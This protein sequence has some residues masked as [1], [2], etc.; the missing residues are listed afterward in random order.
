MNTLRKPVSAVIVA[1]LA[2]TLALTL[3]ITLSSGVAVAEESAPTGTVVSSITVGQMSDIHYFPLEY[4][5]Q[6]VTAADYKDSDFYYSMTGDTKLVLESGNVLYSNMVRVLEDAKKGEAPTHIFASGDLTKNGERVAEIDVANSLRWLQNSVRALGEVKKADDTVVDYTNF[7]IFATV[8]NHDLYN[9]TGALYDKTSGIGWDAEGITAAQFAMI[10]NGLGYPEIDKAILDEI[11]G[12]DYWASDFTGGYIASTNATNLEIT[13]YNEHFTAIQNKNGTAT[14]KEISEEYTQVGDGR[15]QLSFVAHIKDTAFTLFVLDSTDREPTDEIVPV[16]INRTEFDY[17]YT[18][19]NFSEADFRLLKNVDGIDEYVQVTS[20]AEIISAYEND[21]TVYRNTELTHLC[22]GRID[23]ALYPFLEEI[24]DK[25]STSPDGIEEPTYIAS[26]HQNI[27]PHFDQEDEILKDFTM[28]NWEYTC[29]R[30]LELGIK[31]TFS[32]HQHASD[33]ATYVDAEGRT[34]Y[35]FETGSFVSLD[36]PIRYATVTRYNVDGKLAESVD[37]SLRLLDSIGQTP[38]KETPSTDVYNPANEWNEGAYQSALAVYNAAQDDDAKKAAWAEVVAA[39]P[40]YFTYTLHH[41][42]FASLSYNEYIYQEIYGQLIDRVLSHYLNA[43]LRTTVDDL[44]ETY[45]GEDSTLFSGSLSILSGY[46][47]LLYK[48]ANYIVDTVWYNLYPDNDGNGYGDYVVGDKTYDNV[49]DM[50]IAVAYSIIDMEYGTEEAGGKLTL[51]QMAA[52]VLATSCSGNEIS[53][54]LATIAEGVIDTDSLYYTANSPYDE[55]Y[56]KRYQA[57]MQDF[58]AQCDSGK[59]VSDL[60]WGLLNPLYSD[61]DSI[62]KALLDYKFDFINGPTKDEY[63]LDEENEGEVSMLDDLLFLVKGMIPKQ[64]G[65]KVVLNPSNFVLHDIVNGLLPLISSLLG[66]S[67][68]FSFTGTDLYEIVDG[69]LDGYVTDSLFVG[70]GGIAK[71]IVVSFGSDDTPDLAD[72]K[73]PAK[74]LALTPAESLASFTANGKVVTPSYISG[75]RSTDIATQEIGRLPSSLTAN[76]DNVNGTTTFNFSYYTAEEVFTIVRYR[77]V[78]DAEW[79]DATGAHWNIYDETSRNAYYNAS[80]NLEGNVTENGITINTVTSPQYVPL[81]DVGLLCL[82]HGEV[83]YDAVVEGADGEEVEVK[84]YY[85]CKERDA[86]MTG[87][88]LYWNRHNVTISGLEEGAS[89]EYQIYGVYYSTDGEEANRWN[90]ASGLGYDKDFTFTTAKSSGDFKA[91]VISDPQ[92]MIQAMY[93]VTADRMNTLVNDERIQGYDFII[94]G[95]DNTDNPKNFDQWKFWLNSETGIFANTS[96]FSVAGNHEN[97]TYAISKFFNY[98]QPASVTTNVYNGEAEQDY[99]SMDYSGV[100]F[101]FLDT[102]D[103][104]GENGLSEAQYNWLVND[105]STAKTA[106][107]TIVVIMHKSLYSTGSHTNDSEIV[108]M[109]EQLTPVF[110]TYGVKYVFAGH[111]HVYTETKPQGNSGTIYVTLGTIGTKFY[112]YVGDNETVM[113]ALDMDKTIDH[114]LDRQTFGYLTFANGE[115]KYESYTFNDN[116]EVITIEQYLIDTAKNEPV[117]GNLDANDK[118]GLSAGAIAGI[119]IGCVA[120][121]AIIAVGVFFIVKKSKKANGDDEI[122]DY[123]LTEV[124]SDDNNSDAE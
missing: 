13:Y 25:Y 1:V 93:D 110:D 29:K 105:L 11:Y 53:S 16:Q 35:E 54:D 69:L 112:N 28:Y 41:D 85:N 77:K 36:S 122:I 22:G 50:I 90:L 58:A 19:E 123:N 61:D 109:R 117:G 59:L 49:I 104:D 101:A 60:I 119:V 44:V 95:G 21:V 106:G 8:G 80:D 76:F 96:V 67:L 2:L 62:L 71:E 114:T 118:D 97:E 7:Q 81:I 89:Y 65:V 63:K 40:N 37:S 73:D 99:Y 20:Y 26:F 45:L 10:F 103:A 56:R 33:V 48:M 83:Y 72:V 4:C 78:G 82:T 84:M 113:A 108:K 98:T 43:N 86:A 46:R 91:L 12:E 111:D 92:G 55:A 66:D 24:I 115:L 38:L 31:Y 18:A 74:T 124:P 47:V 94:N 70:L 100:H 68:G 42:D 3:G 64:D 5:Y 116:G 32:G 39:N 23:G 15:N 121:V 52:Y 27:M 102:N 30:F 34:L 57:A 6:D 87:S 51:G 9:G 107:K 79:K 17:L 88:L 75:V 120:G 14:A